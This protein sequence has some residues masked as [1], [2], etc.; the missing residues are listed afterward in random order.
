MRSRWF[1]ILQDYM[2]IR[3]AVLASLRLMTQTEIQL[4]ELNQRTLSQW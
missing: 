3:E 2:A 1:L 4:F